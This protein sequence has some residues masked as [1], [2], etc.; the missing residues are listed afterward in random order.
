M[1]LREQAEHNRREENVATYSV[2]DYVWAYG[3]GSGSA[4]Q[5]A[6]IS[7]AM[8]STTG[9]EG[10]GY[11]YWQVWVRFAHGW[12]LRPLERRV[13]RALTPS[14]IHHQRLVGMIPSA[15]IPLPGE[16]S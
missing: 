6:R 16:T 14:E 5:L 9:R 8:R 11:T 1:N 7:T 13:A 2:G 15:G 3:A 4:T 10:R 12:S